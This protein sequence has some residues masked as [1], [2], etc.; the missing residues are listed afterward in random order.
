MVNSSRVF[1]SSSDRD[2]P[3]TSAATDDD[4]ALE[5]TQKLARLLDSDVRLPGGFRIG[6]DGLIGIIPGVGDAIG[7]ALSSW[8]F[9]QAY[10]MG[11]PKRALARI[12]FNIAVDSIL[13]VIPLVGDVFDF[14]WKAN[15]KNMK[16]IE[17]YHRKKQ[18]K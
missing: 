3:V 8:I 6:V 16:I 4:L 13:G 17:K 2:V 5:K 7:G 10:K 14:V 15:V 1:R 18:G 9:Y 11:L 12:G